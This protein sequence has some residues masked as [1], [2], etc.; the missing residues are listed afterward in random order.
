MKN[1]ETLI[2]KLA[3]RRGEVMVTPLTPLPPNQKQ[4]QVELPEAL[5]LPSLE[6]PEQ[7]YDE[8]EA[9]SSWR[10]WVLALGVV[11]IGFW[12]FT[13]VVAPKSGVMSKSGKPQAPVVDTNAARPVRSQAPVVSVPMSDSAASVEK[14]NSEASPKPATAPAAPAARAA[15]VA[16]SPP[17]KAAAVSKKEPAARAASTSAWRETTTPLPAY[18]EANDGS[19]ERSAKPLG[20]GT[21]T[22]APA[23]VLAPSKTVDKSASACSSVHGLALSQCQ[24]CD[25][26]GVLARPFCREQA[27][28]E[29]CQGRYGKTA[30]CPLVGYANGF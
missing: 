10:S 13:A 2:E 4:V 29:Y 6:L 12:M 11:L 25:G 21:A 20:A 18:N 1:S 26:A 30:E 17:A 27:R 14:P 7:T 24:R 3:H 23:A 5:A 9:R 19:I 16:V 15:V 8:P 22:R 28:L